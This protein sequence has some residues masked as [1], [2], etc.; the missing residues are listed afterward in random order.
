MGTMMISWLLAENIISQSAK[1][2]RYGLEVFASGT[3][4]GLDEV[5][6]HRRIAGQAPSGGLQLNSKD[7][8]WRAH[9]QARARNL[10]KSSEN[11]V[12]KR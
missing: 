5:W 10:P 12:S 7:E 8:E 6:S 11:F 4:K 3:G 1:R 9:M 2:I